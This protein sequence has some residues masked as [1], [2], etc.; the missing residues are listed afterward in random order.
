MTLK[1]VPSTT[2]FISTC[3]KTQEH[4]TDSISVSD[5]LR[6]ELLKNLMPSNL[7]LKEFK[8]HYADFLKLKIEDALNCKIS[9]CLQRHSA[10]AKDRSRIVDLIGKITKYFGLHK[11]TFFKAVLIMD[12]FCAKTLEYFFYYFRILKADDLEL[13]GLTSVLLASKY[14]DLDE[15]NIKLL[16]ESVTR[17]KYSDLDFKSKEIEIVKTIQFNID[18]P[19]IYE[20]LE[21]IFADFIFP[22]E[23]SFDVDSL[24]LFSKIKNICGCYTKIC[25]YDY[26]LLKF[27]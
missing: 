26:T 1:S 22:N 15:L 18:Y 10:T 16:V 6:V 19:T 8:D 17:N 24:I 4:C 14:V 2:S 20:L 12:T 3:E 21:F 23:M 27:E 7:C 25:Y 9:L 13:I 5:N 11:N